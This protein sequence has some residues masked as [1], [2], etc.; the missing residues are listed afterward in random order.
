MIGVSETL[1]RARLAA[2]VAVAA[3]ALYGVAAIPLHASMDAQDDALHSFGLCLVLLGLAGSLAVR[4]A[5]LAHRER[6]PV[7]VAAVS[8]AAPRLGAVPPRSLA[9]LQRFRN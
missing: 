6:A 2:A 9:W 4:R 8:G 5:G 1:R 3:V 7:P